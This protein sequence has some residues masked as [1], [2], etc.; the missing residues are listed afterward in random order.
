MIFCACKKDE[1]PDDTT[2]QVTDEIKEEAPDETTED[3]GSSEE[4]TEEIT[5]EEVTTKPAIPPVVYD[6]DSIAPAGVKTYFSNANQ[7]EYDVIKGDDG[8]TYVK[9]TTSG[10]AFNDPFV[11]ELRKKDKG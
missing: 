8:V 6:F 10:T 9:L 4:T 2:S 1:Q 7:T 3:I 11:S 5:T